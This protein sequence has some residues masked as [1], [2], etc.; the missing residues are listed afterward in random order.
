MLEIKTMTVDEFLETK[1]L[2]D[3]KELEC[4]YSLI[5][6]NCKSEYLRLDRGAMPL[7]KCGDRVYGGGDCVDILSHRK[8]YG[9]TIINVG[10]RGDWMCSVNTP[11]MKKRLINFYDGTLEEV[12]EKLKEIIR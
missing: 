1:D 12:Y 8:G 4:M 10:D 3:E 6:D 9:Y 5:R 2:A 7:Y 11:S